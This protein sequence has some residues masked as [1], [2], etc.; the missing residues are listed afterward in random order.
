MNKVS[1]R[2]PGQP[3][4]T[5]TQREIEISREPPLGD[6]PRDLPRECVA[7][8]A[9]EQILD[10]P[11]GKTVNEIRDLPSAAVEVPSSFEMED[12]HTAI[13]D[14]GSADLLL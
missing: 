13:I 11:P 12:L 2:L 8:S 1:A 4:Q 3:R 9:D 5:T 14:D 7:F 10:P 6:A